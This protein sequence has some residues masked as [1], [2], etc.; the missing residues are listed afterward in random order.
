MTVLVPILVG[1]MLLIGAVFVTGAAIGLNRLPDVFTRMHAA[2]KAGTLGSGLMVLALGVY[3]QEWDDF[4][5]AIA[6]V[7]FF[8]L[9]AP[10]SAHLIARTAYIVGYRP[11]AVT[12]LD[13]LQSH[14]RAQELSE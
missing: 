1:L 5:R 12:K 2:S 4:I 8:V 13:E 14:G 6:T 9:T 3:S 11:C 10:V 7:G